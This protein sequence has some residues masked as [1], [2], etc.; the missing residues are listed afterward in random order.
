MSRSINPTTVAKL[1]TSLDKLMG[2]EGNAWSVR[3]PN[4]G[5][6]IR[7]TFHIYSNDPVDV[8]EVLAALKDMGLD[9]YVEN[10]TPQT[11]FTEINAFQG[12]QPEVRLMNVVSEL[13]GLDI[14]ANEAIE[15]NNIAY[16]SHWYG[17]L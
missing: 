12:D 4:D 11:F 17:C 14:A 1:F 5:A 13:K 16:F 10:W 7:L 2:E 15:R 6:D 8:S 3:Y 9:P